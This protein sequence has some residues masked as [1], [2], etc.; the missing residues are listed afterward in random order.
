VDIHTPEGFPVL[1]IGG[2]VGALVVYLAGPTATGELEARP[3]GEPTGRFHTG[4]HCRD[5]SGTAVHVAVYPE[6]VE[7]VY[8]LL[9]DRRTPFVSVWV[10]GGEVSHVD[11]TQRP[12]G[13]EGEGS[14]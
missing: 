9:D 6:V 10:R 14:S 12:R 13:S 5:L 11:L 4:V 1:D 2:D 8:E 3:R 7:G